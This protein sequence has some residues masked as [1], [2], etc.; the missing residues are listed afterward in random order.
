MCHQG[1]IH[2]TDFVTLERGV[3]LKKE[4]LPDVLADWEDSWYNS[5]NFKLM[6]EV[7]FRFSKKLRTFADR[8][9]LFSLKRENRRK[10]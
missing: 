5:T 2:P 8:F 7:V 4:K 1:K 10:V 9:S 3:I 6:S